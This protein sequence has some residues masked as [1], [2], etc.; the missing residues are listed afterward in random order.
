[1]KITNLEKIAATGELNNQ[2]VG[3]KIANN[4]IE[5]H[6][7]ETY[8]LSDNDDELRQNILSVLRTISLAKT[9]TNNLSSYNSKFNNK[10]TLILNAN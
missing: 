5:F 7:P 1:M 10:K 4:K 8:Q 9:L 2:F 6:Y 3:V